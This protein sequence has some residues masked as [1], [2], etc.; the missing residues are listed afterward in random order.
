MNVFAFLK[1]LGKSWVS[2][3]IKSSLD[4]HLSVTG[5]AALVANLNTAG[6]ALA[7]KDNAACADALAD[8][9]LAIH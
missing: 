2:H 5:A 8:V 7:A 3:Q 9:I 4:H 6:T 1:L